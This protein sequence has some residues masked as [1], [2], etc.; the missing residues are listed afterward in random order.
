MLMV[1][2]MLMACRHTAW[3]VATHDSLTHEHTTDTPEAVKFGEIRFR[4]GDRSEAGDR[5]AMA[6]D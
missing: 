3:R 1:D 2:P 6:Q 5:R 4:S